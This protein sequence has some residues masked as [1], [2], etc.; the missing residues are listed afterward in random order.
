MEAGTINSAG[1]RIINIQG[2]LYR[3]HRLAWFYVNGVWP[4]G[5]IDHKNGNSLDN[6]IDN[7]REATFAQNSQNSKKPATNTS[8]YKGVYFSHHANK[9]RAQI[10]VNGRTKNLGYF[11]TK[12]EAYAVYCAAAN[13]YYGEFAR[14]A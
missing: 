12:E 10:S 14:Y 1:Q 13:K 2:K 4:R 3:A 11:Y 8:G 6:S 9:W 5:L 7:L